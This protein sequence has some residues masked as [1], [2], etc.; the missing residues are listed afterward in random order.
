MEYDPNGNQTK[1]IDEEGNATDMK[2]DDIN[3][4]VE[5]LDAENYTSKSIFDNNSNQTQMIDANGNPTVYR[6][7]ALDRLV[8]VEDA[9]TFKMS[10]TY[11]P[12]GNQLSSTDANNNSIYNEYDCLNRLVESKNDLNETALFG[13]DA[14]SNQTQV[15]FPNGNVVSYSYD[16][17]NRVTEVNDHI[18]LVMQYEYDFNS[19]ILTQTDGNSNSVSMQ[20]DGINRM[21]V[22]TDALMEN[23]SLFYDLNSNLTRQIDREGNATNFE[24]DSL[25]RRTLTRDTMN[26]ETIA[27]YD[28]VGNLTKL[29]DDKNNETAYEYDDLYRNTKEIFADNTDKIYIYDGVGNM[30]FRIDNNRDTTRYLYDNIYRL[31]G[32]D[33]PYGD[34]EFSNDELFIYDPGGRMVLNSNGN[35]EITYTYD[36]AN[37]TLSE[38]LNDKTTAYSYDIPNRK[39]TLTYPSGRV[40]EEAYDQRSRLST[41]DEGATNLVNFTYDMGNR[42]TNKSYANGTGCTMTYNANNW[43][44][45]LTHSNDNDFVD[46]EYEHDKVGNKLYAEHNHNTGHSEQ[47]DYDDIYRVTNYKKGTLANNN[48]PNPITQSQYN[49][50]AL[51]NRTTVET[52]GNLTNYASNS[53]N[54]YTQI[55]GGLN[56]TPMYDENGNTLNDGNNNYRYD[57]ENRL[58]SSGNNVNY[59]YDA[60]GRRIQKDIDG[61]IT[62]FYYD[63]AR[64][65]EEQDSNGSTTATY[66]YG[67]WIDDILSMTRSG[68]TYFYHHNALGSV[69]ALTD[70]TG[71]IAERYEYDAYGLATFYTANYDSL[72]SS[73]TFNP[74]L[75]TARRWD[76]ETQLYYYRARHYNPTLGRFMQRDPLGYVDGMNLFEYVG[77]NGV[78]W[79]DPIGLK[80]IQFIF[81]WREWNYLDAH[82]FSYNVEWDY[83][84]NNGK[85][86]MKA[87]PVTFQSRTTSNPD[88]RYKWVEPDFNGSRTYQEEGDCS[89]IE[90]K[91]NVRLMKPEKKLVG[92]EHGWG[93]DL[94]LEIEKKLEA[95]KSNGSGQAKGKSKTKSNSDNVTTKAKAVPSYKYTR[96]Y[97]VVP[98]TLT[99]N[100][101][102]DGKICCD[103][104]NN[105]LIKGFEKLN[106]GMDRKNKLWWN[107][108]MNLL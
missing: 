84:C 88:N 21:T 71:N 16:A 100:I 64:V 55:T 10:Y 26:F 6:Y 87:K 1:M 75:F 14:N 44:T 82:L 107:I 20:Y 43:I 86:F 4:L 77:S 3:R 30:L 78:N 72:T 52:D 51:G 65:I 89:C 79:I 54:A 27:A 34:D 93:I 39:R 67:T 7:D 47:Y 69:T 33:Y 48:I 61:M 85:I 13:Y 49:M 95:Q 66:V 29:I 36:Q 76:T 46:F 41:I 70:A 59:L 105:T 22:Q 38:T 104:K 12:E 18:G 74:Y 35:A 96:K 103:C 83:S 94:E 31:F 62:N 101:D 15:M 9:L 19:N 37:R 42:I 17:V 5:I 57:F 58:L 99:D 97:E 108:Q 25:D 80:K 102:Y 91:L 23:D 8:E 81:G 45:R 53:M 11:D 106:W 68:N 60:L 92:T 28:K 2:Y 40:I 24:Y 98:T 32:R 50:D 90:I 56:A 63:G 73:V